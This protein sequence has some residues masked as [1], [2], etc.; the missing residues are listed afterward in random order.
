MNARGPPEEDE[1]A[2]P[3]TDGNFVV[4]NWARSIDALVSRE[5]IIRA[6][7]AV[8]LAKILIFAPPH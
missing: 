4:G 6:H 7:T 8:M 3:F 5:V 2:L 1:E